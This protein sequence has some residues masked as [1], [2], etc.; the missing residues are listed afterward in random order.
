M[1]TCQILQYDCISFILESDHPLTPFF[2]HLNVL[3]FRF[4]FIS[5]CH[6]LSPSCF[7]PWACDKCAHSEVSEVSLF[8]GCVITFNP[9]PFL[10][11]S[12]RQSKKLFSGT[13]TGGVG[14][15]NMWSHSEFLSNLSHLSSHPEEGEGQV[16]VLRRWV[17]VLYPPTFRKTSAYRSISGQR[18][19]KANK[20]RNA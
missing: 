14:S 1:F 11:S 16:E 10:V 12:L 17:T 9:V 3:Y 18:K 15:D 4:C 5:L 8:Q 7:A 6:S 20:S 13:V 19:R 2:I